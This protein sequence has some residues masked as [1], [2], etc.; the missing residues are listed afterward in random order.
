MRRAALLAPFALA[1]ALWPANASAKPAS[2]KKVSLRVLGKIRVVGGR[3][4]TCRVS[5]MIPDTVRT[6]T[7]DKFQVD[8]GDDSQSCT[9]IN[10]NV[11]SGGPC[12][13]TFHTSCREAPKHYSVTLPK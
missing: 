12:Y 13:V 11:W 9:D 10:G 1:I 5:L 4:E 3:S 6:K 2:A 8:A 7:D